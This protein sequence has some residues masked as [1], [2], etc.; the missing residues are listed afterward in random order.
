MTSQTLNQQSWKWRCN[1]LCQDSYTFEERDNLRWK[2]KDPAYFI[3]EIRQL[4]DTSRKCHQHVSHLAEKLSIL[5]RMLHEVI[6]EIG[7]SPETIRA[8]I[9]DEAYWKLEAEA[10]SSDYE[11][12]V[13][14]YTSIGSNIVCSNLHHGT[15]DRHSPSEEAPVDVSQRT[16]PNT[17]VVTKF[18]H[19]DF[20]NQLSRG[21]ELHLTTVSWRAAKYGQQIAEETLPGYTPPDV[22]EKRMIFVED[23]MARFEADISCDENDNDG[24]REDATP[25][26]LHNRPPKSES[27]ER[28]AKRS[29]RGASELEPPHNGYP[30]TEEAPLYWRQECATADEYDGNA[31]EIAVQCKSSQKEARQA[32]CDIVVSVSKAVCRPQIAH[33]R[34]GSPT[35]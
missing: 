21:L 35:E 32:D 15:I 20:V 13:E 6:K 19:E 7:L 18:G 27:M 23:E 24:G 14:N 8:A 3:S 33:R 4:M 10:I 26:H 12:S 22:K 29:D 16:K 17:P 1:E 30:W 34:Y 2:I 5:C 31:F 9:Q 28:T 25:C 11:H